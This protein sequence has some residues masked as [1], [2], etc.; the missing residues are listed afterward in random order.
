MLGRTDREPGSSSNPARMGRQKKRK[1]LKGLKGQK[2][3]C[4][5]RKL[6]N[7]ITISIASAALAI[8]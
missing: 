5:K 1:R 6:P 4:R 7:V 3:A 2:E 8:R